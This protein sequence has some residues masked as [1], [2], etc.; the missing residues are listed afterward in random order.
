MVTLSFFFQRLQPL[1][2]M[3]YY[4][5]SCIYRL[6]AMNCSSKVATKTKNPKQLKYK[7]VATKKRQTF[8]CLP[9]LS[10][11]KFYYADFTSENDFQEVLFG[12]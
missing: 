8:N 3:F 6:Y 2:F 1:L 12:F 7:K 5:K 4:R 11:T 9:L 10:N